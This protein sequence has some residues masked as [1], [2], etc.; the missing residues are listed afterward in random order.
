M[1]LA[2][3]YRLQDSDKPGFKQLVCVTP[4]TPIFTKGQPTPQA[5]AKGTLGGYIAATANL[6][7]AGRCWVFEGATLAGTARVTGDAVV[8]GDAVITE[9][10][11]IGGMAIIDCEAI[12]RGN[13][14]VLEQATVTGNALI[15]G[16]AKIYGNAKIGGW[17]HV[18]GDSRVCGDALIIGAK[19]GSD[20]YGVFIHSTDA[21]TTRIYGAVQI[22]GFADVG[23]CLSGWEGRQEVR[24]C[25]LA[26]LQSEDQDKC[27]LV[28]DNARIS[29]CAQLLGEVA[30]IKNAVI[31]G[32]EVLTEGTISDSSLVTNCPEDESA[33][34][35]APPL[36]LPDCG[37]DFSEYVRVNQAP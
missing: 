2:L 3:K 28:K 33:C 15:E 10:A 20:G 7:H 35:V 27:V 1:A 9:G 16:S 29:G 36:P 21:G 37:G 5:I 11:V 8:I 31:Y 19:N 34:E 12:V 30:A 14:R 17:T 23:G 32:S 24:V 13:A 6:S 22:S 4:F 18:T 26:V 25:G